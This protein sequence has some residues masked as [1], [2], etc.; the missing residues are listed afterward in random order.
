MATV[1]I[2]PEEAGILSGLLEERI[3][4]LA[5]EIHHSIVSTFTEELKTR[6]A[7]LETLKTKLDSVSD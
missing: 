3:G 7:G 5:S 4:E 2:T 6:K 1:D